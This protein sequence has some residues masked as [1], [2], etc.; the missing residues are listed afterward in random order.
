MDTTGSSERA[1]RGPDPTAR[2]AP[3]NLRSTTYSIT[4]T[5]THG[6]AMSAVKRAKD[7]PLAVN[8]NRFVRLETGSSNDAEFAR[9]VHAYTYGFGR[10][11]ARAAVANT[12]GVSSTTVASRLSTAVTSDAAANTATSSR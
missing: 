3:K 9:C 12:T 8:A 6:S 7:R 10:T 4:T 11:P 2:S 5:V 1:G